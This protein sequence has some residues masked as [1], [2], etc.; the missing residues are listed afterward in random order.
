MPLRAQ[1]LG[2]NN[3]G[4]NPGGP[5]SFWHLTGPLFLTCKVQ[6]TIEATSVVGR[7]DK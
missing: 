1:A 5:Q 7:R 6:L 3:L 4:L 2:Q